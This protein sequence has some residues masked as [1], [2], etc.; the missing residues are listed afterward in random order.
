MHRRSF[1]FAGLA[2]SLFLLSA[3]SPAQLGQPYL[4]PGEILPPLASQAL[5][6]KWLDIASSNRGSPA[7]VV[8]SF[9]RAGGRDAQLWTQRLMKDDPHLTIYTVIFLE[10]VP[11]LFRAMAVSGI[12]DGMPPAL[13]D[14]TIL[15]YR[16]EDLWRQRLQVGNERLCDT[17]GANRPGSMDDVWAVC[18]RT[19]FGIQQ[20]EASLEL[21][22]CRSPCGSVVQSKDYSFRGRASNRRV[23][24]RGLIG[25]DTSASQLLSAISRLWLD[26]R[27]FVSYLEELMKLVTQI[28][29]SKGLL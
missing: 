26:D 1:F 11:G 16:D 29:A 2:I 17:A 8:F 18:G 10:S 19:L 12:K 7:V 27:L 24:R 21:R 15:L 14:R 28:F 3:H 23:T 9:S 6:G 4:K 20:I 22:I 13:Q 25:N 5:T